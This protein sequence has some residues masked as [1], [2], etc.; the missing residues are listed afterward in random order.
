MSAARPAG[1]RV[2]FFALVA[3]CALLLA[4]PAVAAGDAFASQVAAAK[5]A[6]MADPEAA[7]AHAR[8]AGRSAAAASTSGARELAAAEARW[9]EGEAL[10]R[11]NQPARARPVIESA[12]ATARRLQPRG[13]LHANLLMAAGSIDWMTGSAGRA[14]ERFQASHAISGALGEKRLQAR[15]LQAIGIIYLD[16]RDYPRTLRYYQQSAEAFGGDPALNVANFNNQGNALKEMGRLTEA[17]RS[18]RRAL[19]TAREMRSPFL[20][21]RILTN[22]A[23][24]QVLAGA[25]ARADETANVGLVLAS[26]HDKGWEPFLWGVK[27]QS[28]LARGDLVAARRYFERT[29]TG[30]DLTRTTVQFREF[31]DSASRFYR[32]TGD[33]RL[34]LEHLAAFKRLDDEVREVAAST[35]AALATAR[36]DF[37][38]QE[39]KIANLRAAKLAR[40]IEVAEQQQRLNR[41]RL[42]SLYAALSIAVLAG[43]GSLVAL[44]SIRRSRNAA[45]T[46]NEALT[47]VNRELEQALG[48]RTRFLATTSHEIRTPLNGILGMTQIMRH[49]RRLAAD[50]LDR[51]R[52]VH[53]AGMT[54]KALVDDI[55]DLAK[56]ERGDIVIESEPVELRVLLDGVARLWVGQAGMKGTAVAV[57]LDRCPERVIGDARRLR[58]IVFNLMSNAVKFTEGGRVSLSAWAAQGEVIVRVADTGVGIPREQFDRIFE[59]F[60]QVDGEVTRR[61]G[62]TGLGLAISRDLVRAMGGR[63]DLES[64]VGVGSIFSIHLPLRPA[65]AVDQPADVTSGAVDFVDAG[66]L[67]VENNPLTRSV[68]AAALDGRAGRVWGVPGR[69]AIDAMRRRRPSLL[70]VDYDSIGGELSLAMLVAA[71][72]APLSTVLLVG[73]PLDVDTLASL[74]TIG[75]EEVIVRPIAP[76]QLVNAVERAHAERQEGAIAAAA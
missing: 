71:A 56:W 34:A 64:E 44:L 10:T 75:V 21:V 31:H 50:Q 17:I 25:L 42:L 58:Q 5:A 51:V 47:G 13:K 19:A 62:G 7:L 11:L 33:F 15:A 69:H 65:E 14:L 76:L 9:L 59:S 20:E 29:F 26:G 43:A 30:T 1:P 53:E 18:Y 67:V 41:V 46:A 4:S 54:M 12:L 16:A 63:F 60:H 73:E 61:F 28:A 74:A 23:S 36:F 52:I 49:D 48:A 68:I 8:E 3:A 70:V 72:D 35:T 6:M 39:L 40:D 27:G 2:H 22:I 32:Q 37:A 45:R 55:L 24:A 38:N 66:V 57:D